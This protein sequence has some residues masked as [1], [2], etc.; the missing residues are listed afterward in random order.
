MSQT[1]VFEELDEG[2]RDYLTA[3]R[4]AEGAGS[5]GVFAPT[6]SALAGCGCVAG[7]VIIGLTLAFT[8]TT[9]IDVVYDDPV[10]VAMLQTAGIL[11]GGWLLFAAFRAGR[12]KGSKKVAGNWVYAD[13]LHLYEAY[14]EQVTVTKID[15]VVEANFTHNYNNGAYQNSVVR[16]VMSGNATAQVTLNNEQRAEQMVV[17]LNYL[18]W[19]RGPD[20]GE[21]GALAPATL[22]GLAKYVAK[23]DVE[24]KDAEDNINLNL[25]E[26]DIT[27]VPEEP[28]R[29]G[30]AAPAIIP[31]IVLVL[32]GA[33]VFYLMAYVINPPIRDDAIFET[34]T[35]EP[36]VE[37]RFLRAYL[38]DPRNTRHRTEVLQRLSRFYDPAVNHVSQK[39]TE[40][41]LRNGMVK[42][43]NSLRESDSP[44]VSLRVREQPAG[45]PGAAERE[46]KLRDGISDGVMTEFGKV[47]PPISI[48]NVVITPPPP[49]IGHQ[50]IAFVKAPEDAANAHFDVTYELIPANNPNLYWVTIKI[51]I[52]DNVEQP[53]VTAFAF[54]QLGPYTSGAIDTTVMD[55]VKNKI[56]TAMVGNAGP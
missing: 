8:L 46:E 19:A 49:P 54:E 12:S 56:I 21:R 9:W 14:R 10:R 30:R 34:V 51:E 23:H 43:L 38:I 28:T 20:G 45:R 15:D 42:V 36:G 7:P 3:V 1:F 52:R 35:R 24:P 29:E 18:A 44:V 40:P 25:V 6:A 5:P 39:A 11:V 4:D 53:P 48:P 33:G 55:D 13:P 31:Y 2:T 27:E 37:P 26:L 41:D 22:G 47:M 50:L 16:V 17:Y 32:A